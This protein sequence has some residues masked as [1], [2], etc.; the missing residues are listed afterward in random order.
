MHELSIATA[1]VEQA[2]DIARADGVD[3][4]SS[5]TVR[6]GEL[7]G[8]VPDALHFAFE[9]ARDGTALAAARLIVEQVP[10]RAWC[11]GCAE[12]F[13]VGVPPFFWCPHCDRPSRE[14]RSGRELE[15]T[16][17]AAAPA[18]A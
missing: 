4:V 3:G 2:A 13:A 6:V 8:V 10:A 1:I 12:E 16:G 17:V 11:G 18:P 9:V 5:V 15:I 14:L 7:A